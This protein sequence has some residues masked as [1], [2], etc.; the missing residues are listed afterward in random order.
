[1][2]PRSVSVFGRRIPVLALLAG[3]L[4]IG[5][6]LSV[7]IALSTQHHPPHPSRQA[8]T[9]PLGP[10]SAAAS[11]SSSRTT[12]RGPGRHSPRA[13]V[14]TTPL[15]QPHASLAPGDGQLRLSA[16]DPVHLSIPA[17]GVSSGMLQLGLNPDRSVE[18]PPLSQVSTPG[19]YKYSP[20]PG[21]A[22]SSV[23]LGHVDSYAAP[24]VFFRLGALRPGD[25]VD[26]TRADGAIAVFRVD[27]VK[28]FPKS[29]FPTKLVYYPTSYPSLKLV[30]CGGRFDAASGNYLDNVIAFATLV[31]SRH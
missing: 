6:V 12:S 31:S 14:S 9:A 15:P 8:A 3:V 22:G 21:V 10:T 18:V 25:E 26:V 7:L 27:G 11:S 20:A 4:V 24:G 23:M 19:W 17:I 1:M 5:G 13:P 16:S 2:M 30:T 28:E 29:A